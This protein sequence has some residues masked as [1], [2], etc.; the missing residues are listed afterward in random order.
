MIA[1][2]EYLSDV[3]IEETTYSTDDNSVFKSASIVTEE[4]IPEVF[5]K[6]RTRDTASFDK[7]R[8]YM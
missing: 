8:A 6:N 5:N 1:E 3:S 2:Y 7:K 4:V